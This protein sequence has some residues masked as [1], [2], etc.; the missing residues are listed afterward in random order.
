[1]PLRRLG[2]FT[3][4][5]IP[6]FTFENSLATR[7]NRELHHVTLSRAAVNDDVTARFVRCE[8]IF[9][10]ISLTSRLVRKCSKVNELLLTS[11][12]ARGQA[13]SVTPRRPLR[14]EQL[15]FLVFY[16]FIF[17]FFSV[18]V[19]LIDGAVKERRR[20]FFFVVFFFEYSGSC[21]ICVV[22][23]LVVLKRHIDAFKFKLVIWN[24][25]GLVKERV[26]CG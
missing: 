25:L 12:T 4:P 15:L 1:M 10:F 21:R 5:R 26:R 13:R 14:V 23:Q 19:G 22:A 6:L 8:L 9:K 3:S 17:L 20:G 2:S 11:T 18:I 7:L 24:L 16:F